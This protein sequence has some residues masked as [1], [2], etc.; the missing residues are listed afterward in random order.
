MI[1]RDSKTPSNKEATRECDD[2]TLYCNICCRLF[3]RKGG[4]ITHMKIHAVASKINVHIN[5][6]LCSILF[7]FLASIFL[8]FFLVF[9]TVCMCKARLSFICTCIYV[10]L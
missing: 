6:H 1:P 4:F 5:I 10:L 9:L 7:G 8:A 3:K 2:E